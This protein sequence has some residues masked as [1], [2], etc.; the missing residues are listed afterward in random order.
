MNNV[1]GKSPT[2]T[3]IYDQVSNLKQSH[4]DKELKFS[5][6]SMGGDK[7]VTTKMFES[8]STMG[9]ILAY[10]GCDDGT[11]VKE[12]CLTELKNQL[13]EQISNQK[14]DL[15]SDQKDKLTKA[16]NSLDLDSFLKNQ[17][18]GTTAPKLTANILMH[19]AEKIK[20]D[21]TTTMKLYSTNSRAAASPATAATPLKTNVVELLMDKTTL[22]QT[23]ARI[24][25]LNQVLRNDKTVHLEN[26]NLEVADKNLI[27]DYQQ[28]SNN[29]FSSFEAI[30]S[31]IETLQNRLD[32]HNQACET[33]KDGVKLLEQAVCKMPQEQAELKKAELKTTLENHGLREKNNAYQF[34][35]TY[36]LKLTINLKKHLGISLGTMEYS[37]KDPEKY[38]QGEITKLKQKVKDLDTTSTSDAPNHPQIDYPQ[39]HEECAQ[40]FAKIRKRT[41]LDQDKT[42]EQINQE[43]DANQHLYP[44]F[45]NYL[46]ALSEATNQT[47]NTKY[48]KN[49][50]IKNMLTSIEAAASSKNGPF[51][52]K[53]PIKNAL[54]SW[55]TKSNT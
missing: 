55:F 9:K 14:S 10:F 24:K 32:I 2:S 16:V 39:A 3:Y 26:S 38:I 43:L 33:I 48:T 45:L 28:K 23:K 27:K 42:L 49:D 34:L 35:K 5:S 1:T 13:K 53:E 31:Q 47:T 18:D 19:F 7:T 51:I 12:Q 36:D 4:G 40:L 30:T 54:T 52:M 8:S 6:F 41:H 50:I 22:D 29:Y 15:T 11:Q 25:I 46:N 17:G 20:R 21:L 37:S 44:N